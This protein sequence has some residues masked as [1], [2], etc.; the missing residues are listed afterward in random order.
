MKVADNGMLLSHH[1]HT[2][3]YGAH[4]LNLLSEHIHGL[5]Q[6][7]ETKQSERYIAHHSKHSTRMSC[8]RFIAFF[9]S[10][11]IK[12]IVTEQQRVQCSYFF[13]I[14]FNLF[15]FFCSFLWFVLTFVMKL[16]WFFRS[17]SFRIPT[18]CINFV[19]SI[20]L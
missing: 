3:E 9:S 11:L 12:L 20:G 10:Q 15:S 2:T 7:E 4:L 18:F 19:L 16:G 13:S 1:I 17:N 6:K 14:R 8:N 5:V